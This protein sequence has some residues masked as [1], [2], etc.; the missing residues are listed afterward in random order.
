[1]LHWVDA[2]SAREC[3]RVTSLDAVRQVVC[4]ADRETAV[5]C[6]ES[7]VA[8]WGISRDELALRLSPDSARDRLRLA[9]VRGGLGSGAESVVAQRLI[10]SGL[11][12]V[13]QWSPGGLGRVDF[14]VAG[15]RVVVEVDGYEFHKGRTEFE[16]DRLRDA[17][18]AARGYVVIRLTLAQIF[19]SWD[20]CER[21]VRAAV[22]SFPA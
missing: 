11:R 6:M 4:W 9:S 15:S 21:R 19:D 7:A 16:R 1:M 3:W 8:A 14:L 20:E 10:R 13:A 18:L 17:E 5:A 12:L 22:A 2:S